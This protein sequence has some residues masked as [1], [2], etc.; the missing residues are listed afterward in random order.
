[1]TRDVLTTEQAAELLQV[2]T[3]T[4]KAKARAGLIP[5]AKIG[6]AW[7]FSRPALMKWLETGGLDY[8]AV[9]EQGLADAV[10]EAMAAST[11]RTYSAAEVRERFGL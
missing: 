9:V 1:M 10:R 11:G 6:R 8:E 2:S 7:R 5:A 4:L 3:A